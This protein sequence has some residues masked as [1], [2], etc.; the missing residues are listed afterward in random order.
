MLLQLSINTYNK[1]IVEN[2]GAEPLKPVTETQFCFFQLLLVA[3]VVCVERGICVPRPNPITLVAPVLPA[4]YVPPV[5]YDYSDPTPALYAP[6]NAYPY[7]Y[8]E[9]PSKRFSNDYAET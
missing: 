9:Y 8:G 3:L 4:L 5:S 2:S 6:Y 1:K 7:P